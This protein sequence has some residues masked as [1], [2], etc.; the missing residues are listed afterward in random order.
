MDIG[1]GDEEEHAVMLYNMLYYNALKERGTR[2]PILIIIKT[3]QIIVITIIIMTFIM[4]ITIRIFRKSLLIKMSLSLS[5][6]LTHTHTHTPTGVVSG[7]EESEGPE[8][9]P[10]NNNNG[11]GTGGGN[12]GGGGVEGGGGED[13]SEQSLLIKSKGRGVKQSNNNN[14]KGANLKGNSAIDLWHDS[15]PLKIVF[16]SSLPLLYS[17]LLSSISRYCTLHHSLLRLSHFAASS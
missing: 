1:A 17:P 7:P 9:D 8:S 6:S 15:Y 3:I 11:S 13:N 12:G 5:L 4:I 14:N 16:H 10:T 2:T